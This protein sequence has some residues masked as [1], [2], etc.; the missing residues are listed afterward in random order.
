[1]LCEA[2]DGAFDF[3]RVPNSDS[4]PMRRMRW[5]CWART[6]QGSPADAAPPSSEM[7]SRRFISRPGPAINTS[8]LRS[9]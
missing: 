9:K 6:A 2:G 4:T 1:L 3:R 5:F 8:V 7:N